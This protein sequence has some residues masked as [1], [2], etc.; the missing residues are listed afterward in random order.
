MPCSCAW[1]ASARTSAGVYT[2]PTSVVFVMLTASG[3]ARC[4]SPQP[5]ASVSTNLGLSLPSGVGTV[6]SLRPLT[7]SG[8]PPSSVWMWAVP[9]AMTAPQRGMSA[10]R[11]STFAPVP[12]KTGKTSACSPNSARTTSVRRAVYWSSPYEI[13]WPPFASV[14][15]ASTSGCAP[16]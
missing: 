9:L 13:W 11:A 12:L 5:K 16:A 14:R 1:S 8:A 3:C 2:V 10:V 15:A 4:S 6:K 7:R